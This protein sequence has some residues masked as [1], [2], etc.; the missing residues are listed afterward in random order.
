LSGAGP[1]PD[2][3]LPALERLV[4]HS[5]REPALLQQAVTHASLLARRAD[6]AGTGYERLEFLG[7]RVLGLLVAELLFRDFPAEDEGALAR[8]FAALV[9]REGLARVAGK[10]GLGAF[11]RLGPGERDGGGRD[12]PALLADACEAVIGALYL[13]GGLEAARRFVEPNW[14]P[15][16]AEEL[17]PPQDAKTALQEWAQGHGLPLPVYR[18]VSAEG[19]PHDPRFTVEVR[20]ADK[21]TAAGAGRSKRAAEQLAAQALLRQLLDQ[22]G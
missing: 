9:S 2:L 13:D 7:D 15:L 8:R 20:V 22:N 4:G 18:L 1:R 5:F 16:V 19:P 6:R 3:G 21:G 14:R 11:L 17:R 10:L 12:N